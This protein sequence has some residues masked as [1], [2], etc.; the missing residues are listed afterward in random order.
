L[1]ADL[2]YLE[3]SAYLYGNFYPNIAMSM[4]LQDLQ[5]ALV[6]VQE[7]LQRVRGRLDELEKVIS[8]ENDE[9]GIRRIYIE[10]TDFVL[11]PAHDQRGIAIHLGADQEGGY[12]HLHYPGTGIPAVDIGF[13][14][15]GD[16]HLQLKGRDFKPQVDILT[17]DNCGFVA[18][19]SENNHP[20]ALMR[21]QPHGGSVA[22]LQEDGKA[23]A[24][25]VFN[26]HEPATEEGQ[27]S[28]ASTCLLFGDAAGHTSIKLQTDEDGS[29]ITAGIK[30]QPDAVALLS[31]KDG[32]A[33]LMHS[34]EDKNSVSILAMNV[35]AEICAHENKLPGSGTY[36]GMT[37]GEYGSSQSLRGIGGEK[38]VDISALD[39]AN[40]FTLHD[41]QG[42]VRV[43]LAHHFGSHSAMTLQGDTEHEGIRAISSADVSS[44]EV[45]SPIDHDTKILTAVTAEKAVTI[46]QKEHRPIVMI[47]EGDQGGM[48]CAY[49]PSNENAGI[50]SLSGGPVSGSV[51][52]ATVD[53]TAQLTLDA[54]DHG[55]RLLIN[56]DLGFQRVAMGVYEEA[57][58]LHLNN[59]GSIGIQAI[60]TP[61]GGIVTV[62]DHH[63]RPI[64]TLPD[65][66]DEDTGDWGKLPDSF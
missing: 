43:M 6:A 3:A 7:E 8:I 25:L 40:T 16:P 48:V 54:T 45:M 66:D 49:G 63:G 15:I 36:A 62:S 31:R 52:L 24:A 46:V 55:G 9:D 13:E 18:V 1:D 64:A 35:G 38:A 12:F 57:G 33:L 65:N 56:N 11:R 22:V 29:M 27:P 20:G 5:A 61:K 59:T 10:C 23:R 4:T 51:V 41:A 26:A 50:A 37:A 14:A 21:A 58:G 32:S 28:K 44:L 42:E 34:P 47:G 17:K 53:G 2:L 60:A 19:L 39:I 30:G